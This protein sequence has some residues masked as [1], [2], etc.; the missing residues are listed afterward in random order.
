MGVEVVPAAAVRVDLDADLG[1]LIR[2]GVGH[3]LAHRV[4]GGIVEV[5]R[6]AQA[7]TRVHA[8]LAEHPARTLEL[9]L[10]GLGVI[11]ATH[12]VACPR[13]AVADAVSNLA[14]AA[15]DV[16]HDRLAVDAQID[17]AAHLDVAC[18]VIARRVGGVTVGTL[19]TRRDDGQLDPARVHG[20]VG[21]ER[22]T[23]DRLVG[24]RGRG[25]GHVDLAGARGGQG[26]VLGHEHDDNALDVGLLAVV[27]RV[28]L[29]NGLL[30]AIPLHKLVAPRAYGVGA[31]VGAIGVLGHDA[32][33]GKRV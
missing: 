24:E 10:S 19:G 3:G 25:V 29:K 12:A 2:E 13:H 20:V 4:A 8:V 18:H 31:V 32:H 26:S 21:L 14:V 15:Q 16:I 30:A 27:T 23:L 1:H 22:V 33:V 11:V 28:G 17:G 7:L 5:K 6:A 9:G